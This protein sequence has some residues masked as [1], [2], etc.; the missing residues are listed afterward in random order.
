MKPCF[1]MNL[2]NKRIFIIA[3]LVNQNCAS[4]MVF[5]VAQH[6]DIA[7]M[8]AGRMI[9]GEYGISAFCTEMHHHKIIEYKRIH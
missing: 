4:M 7:F 1:S 6:Y 5:G 9:R 2:Q 8:E 3:I